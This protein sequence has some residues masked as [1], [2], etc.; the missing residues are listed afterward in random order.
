[1]GLFSKTE[2]VMIEGIIARVGIVSHSDHSMWYGLHLQGHKGRFH[3]S[4]TVG[5]TGT[6]V[7]ADL[8]MAQR[9]D[10][11]RFGT[12]PKRPLEVI[13]SFENLT[14]TTDVR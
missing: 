13:D 8:S 6:E 7:N 1:M 3:A 12:H 10:R 9:G 14:M 4:H 11:V 5:R 2:P